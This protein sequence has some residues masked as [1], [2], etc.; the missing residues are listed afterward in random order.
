NTVFI[1]V[2]NAILV[3][4]F[5]N[6]TG[7]RTYRSGIFRRE[8]KIQRMIHIAV[9]AR[10]HLDERQTCKISTASTSSGNYS[11]AVILIRERRHARVFYSEK[12]IA[13]QFP[14]ACAELPSR[15]RNNKIV[16]IGL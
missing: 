10:T 2:L 16:C 12:Q 1:W 8:T 9:A 3:I 6:K 14:G 5:P 13:V 7:N 4:V 15:S 11:V